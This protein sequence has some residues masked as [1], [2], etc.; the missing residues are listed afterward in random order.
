M[1]QSCSC[2]PLWKAFRFPNKCIL[3]NVRVTP[4]AEH[5]LA[6]DSSITSKLFVGKALHPLS[7]QGEVSLFIPNDQQ[8][9]PPVSRPAD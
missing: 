8:I 9:L 1:S 7:N 6:L 3:K 4:R 2:H 5:I